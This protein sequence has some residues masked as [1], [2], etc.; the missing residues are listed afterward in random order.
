MKTNTIF[1]I[2]ALAMGAATLEF[3]L[4]AK[5]YTCDLPAMT[6]APA[7][8]YT[9]NVNIAPGGITITRT[10]QPW[11]PNDAGSLTAQ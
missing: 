7:N 3:T 4:G 6:Y 11:T 5:A 9:W 2:A 1:M 10:I 8:E